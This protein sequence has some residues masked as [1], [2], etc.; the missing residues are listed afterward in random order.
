MTPFTLTP[1]DCKHCKNWKKLSRKAVMNVGAGK[2]R[3]VGVCKMRTD[4]DECVITTETNRCDDW[5]EQ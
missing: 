5:E 4:Q 1:R 3:T 2:P